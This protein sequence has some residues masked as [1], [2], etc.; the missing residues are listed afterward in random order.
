[1]GGCIIGSHIYIICSD[2]ARNG[3]TLF[4]RLY[5]DCLALSGTDRLH[6]FDTDFPGGDLARYFPDNSDILDIS[7][8]D[9]Q[10]RLFDTMINNPQINYVVDLQSSLLSRFF[11]I[12]S[13]IGFDEGAA[14]AGIGV[15]VFFVVDRSMSSIHAADHIRSKLTC[16]EFVLV[17]NDSI[18]NLL[19]IPSAAREYSEIQKDRDLVL[20]KFSEAARNFIEQPQFSFADF[21]AGHYSSAPLEIR[22]ELWSFLEKIYN[23]REPG[24]SGVTHLF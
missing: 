10:V 9:G 16:S 3:K 13:D 24:G 7:K 17:R 12:F 5:A 14:E 2:Q 8:T 4:A 23:Q 20:P 15:V 22:H 6:I 19:H 18:G 1:M 11:K 21:I